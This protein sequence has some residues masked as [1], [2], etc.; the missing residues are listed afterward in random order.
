MQDRCEI[1]FILSALAWL[2]I[3]ANTF[4]VVVVVVG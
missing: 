4:I 3:A 1:V 2:D